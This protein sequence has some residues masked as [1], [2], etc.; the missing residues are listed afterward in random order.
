VPVPFIFACTTA[1]RYDR[2]PARAAAVR[3]QA[4]SV[5]GQEAGM[6]QTVQAYFRVARARSDR[7][8][9]EWGGRFGHIVEQRVR[10]EID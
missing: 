2:S 6:F 10:L 5:A 3:E 1:G 9:E 8:R 7:D 4:A